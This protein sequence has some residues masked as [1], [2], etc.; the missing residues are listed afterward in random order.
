MERANH[1]QLGARGPGNH[2]LIWSVASAAALAAFF[3]A[4]SWF[5]S[6]YRSEP[7][8]HFSRTL[9]QSLVGDLERGLRHGIPPNRLIGVRELLVATLDDYPEL[10]QITIT[11]LQGQVLYSAGGDA[12][13]PPD[14]ALE[15]A[16]L[17]LPVV[18]D[19]G[20]Q[21]LLHLIPRSHSWSVELIQLGLVLAALWLGMLPLVGAFTAP[22]RLSPPPGGVDLGAT[23]RITTLP[24]AFGAT[25]VVPVVPYHLAATGQVDNLT[26]TMALVVALLAVCS[27]LA[28]AARDRWSLPGG[29]GGGVVALGLGCAV[30]AFEGPQGMWLGA[31]LLGVGSGWLL[32]GAR[33]PIGAGATTGA[34]ISGA[35]LGTLVA[36][37]LGTTVALGMAAAVHGTLLVA[38]SLGY[39]P[40]AVAMDTRAPQP[41]QD[42]QG[43]HNPALPWLAAGFTAATAGLLVGVGLLA[44][45]LMVVAMAGQPIAVGAAIALLALMANLA[46]V[47]ARSILG[48]GVP[49]LLVAGSSGFAAAWTTA[50]LLWEPSWLALLSMAAGMGVGLGGLVACQRHWL[51]FDPERPVA[52]LWLYGATGLGGGLAAALYALATPSLGLAGATIAVGTA[53]LGLVVLLGVLALSL[54]IP[55]GHAP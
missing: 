29:E 44:I 37:Y 17:R 30:A 45:P 46:A 51:D 55:E 20:P 43:N 4:V 12:Q 10:A 33:L 39:L 42:P 53:T 25:F 11:D 16:S 48:R 26:G 40:W 23:R 22:P 2:W 19:Q 3:A 28:A 21:L 7:L 24:L 27:A 6:A 1:R 9:G 50:L 35:L 34:G 49:S 5:Y 14:A 13:I 41:P 36:Q 47:L 52:A 32:G 18:D 54:D 31:C 15:E 38:G 8:E